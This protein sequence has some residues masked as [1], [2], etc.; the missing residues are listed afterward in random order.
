MRDAVRDKQEGED[1]PH[2]CFKRIASASPRASLIAARREGVDHVTRVT[3]R[4]GCRESRTGG[5]D[6]PEAD[7]R[8]ARSGVIALA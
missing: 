2:T 5:E 4:E 1:E 7:V 8:S 3:D 6:F